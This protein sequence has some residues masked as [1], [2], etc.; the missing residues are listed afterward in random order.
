MNINKLIFLSKICFCFAI[1]PSLAR[2]SRS[3]PR[4]INLYYSKKL[5]LSNIIINS[6]SVDNYNFLPLNH[7][8]SSPSLRINNHVS[9]SVLS[10]TRTLNFQMV[11][12]III[13][14]LDNL[15]NRRI[16]TEKF[17]LLTCNR[18]L[19]RDGNCPATKRS[20]PGQTCRE[21][22]NHPLGN[23]CVHSRELEECH[24]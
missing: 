19:G 16:Q 24:R 20:A 12:Y 22:V 2:S 21:S 8:Q 18:V 4:S 9:I 15:N 10:P 17:I 11:I 6:S 1:K 7:H 13:D 23:Q 14:I 5:A 3:I